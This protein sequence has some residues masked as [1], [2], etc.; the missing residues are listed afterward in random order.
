MRKCL[1]I[2]L[3]F[4]LVSCES[5]KEE[6]Q[7]VFTGKYPNPDKQAPASM[8]SNIKIGELVAKYTVGKPLNITENLIIEGKV[9]TT[10]QP[11]NFYKSFYIQDETGGI[12]I[13]IGKNSLYNDYHPGQ[14]IYVNCNDLTIGMYGL[15]GG[16]GMVQVGFKDVNPKYETAYIENQFIIDNHIFKG[17]MGPKVE[18]KV[19]SETDLPT[20]KQTQ[21]TNSNIGKLVT[22]ND[23]TY[24][25]YDSKYKKTSKVFLLMYL[26]SNK[27]KT[28]PHNRLFITE[29][30]TKVTTWALSKELMTKK[31]L[32]G[33][34]DNFQIGSGNSK[35]DFVKDYKA[36]GTYPGI[37]KNA[38]AVSHYFSTENGTAIQV[39]TSGYS[40]FAD[41]E[42][43]KAILDGSKKLSVT[44]ILTLYEGKIQITVNDITDLKVQD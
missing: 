23:L 20:D 17:A 24:G 32:K 4:A 10:D 6:F 11:G 25:W 21:A 15:D 42:I 16:Y 7:P 31:L 43:D 39:R 29:G 26:D 19:I 1:V 12:E 13:K 14:T 33:D 18:P 34:W 9:S 44:G 35:Y 22:I 3:L 8:K 37:E 36:D 2:A 30:D 28:E 27:D 38:Y 41:T 40:K 5:L